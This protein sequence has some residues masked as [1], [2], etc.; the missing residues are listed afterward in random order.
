MIATGSEVAIAA[1]PRGCCNKRAAA[2]GWCPCR[3]APCS[4][5][6]TPRTANGAAAAVARRVAIEAG[7]TVVVALR[8][9]RGG[10]IGIDASAPPAAPDLFRHFGFTAENVVAVVELL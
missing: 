10:V 4:T 1:R 2:C 3:H 8:R 9:A 6:R 5:R 7:A